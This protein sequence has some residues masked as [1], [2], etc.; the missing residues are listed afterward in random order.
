M[1]QFFDFYQSTLFRD[2]ICHNN[3]LA[4]LFAGGQGVAF[5]RFSVTYAR[6]IISGL[7]CPCTPTKPLRRQKPRCRVSGHKNCTSLALVGNAK[8]SPRG[9]SPIHIRR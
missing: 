5:I 9:F 4:Y 6:G 2:G 8:V 7:T 3:V 1:S